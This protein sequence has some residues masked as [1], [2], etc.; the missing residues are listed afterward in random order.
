MSKIYGLKFGS[1]DS[2]SYTGL[3]PTFTIFSVSGTSA[4][5]APGITETPASSGLYQ[6]TYGPTQTIIFKVDGGSN[7]ASSDRYLYGIL[8]PIQAVDQSTGLSTDSF[9]STSVDPTTIFGYI[10]RLLEF[11]EGNATYTK[12]SGAWNVYSRGSSTLLR[13][14]TLADST[15]SSTK[16]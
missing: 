3:T 10:K 2:A 5:S 11:L 4:I 8:D 7:L 6:F 14:K 16:T 1:G 12:S 15:T 13:V 9:G